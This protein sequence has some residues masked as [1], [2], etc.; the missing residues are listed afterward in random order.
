MK[1]AINK[2]FSALEHLQDSSAE[3]FKDFKTPKH[4]LVEKMRHSLQESVKNLEDNDV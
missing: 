1:L 4:E 3:I 2:Y